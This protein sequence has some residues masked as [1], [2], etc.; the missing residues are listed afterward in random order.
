MKCKE[1]AW[2]LW[3]PFEKDYPCAGLCANPDQPVFRIFSDCGCD[4]GIACGD[5]CDGKDCPKFPKGR[6]S[7]FR[8][9]GEKL[10]VAE[11]KRVARILNG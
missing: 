8:K 9:L 10:L 1:C 6:N 2:S 3:G 5:R 4:S 7:I 11:P